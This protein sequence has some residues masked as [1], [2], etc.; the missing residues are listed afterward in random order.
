LLSEFS[1]ALEKIENFVPPRMFG[2]RLLLAEGQE[3]FEK[4]A[5]VLPQRYSFEVRITT[6]VLGCTYILCHKTRH[7]TGRGYNPEQK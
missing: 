1:A 3:V 7:L 2:S 6:Q 5:E 4:L